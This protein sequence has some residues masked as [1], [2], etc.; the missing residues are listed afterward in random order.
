MKKFLSLFLSF[1]FIANSFLFGQ[2]A[3]SEPLNSENTEMVSNDISFNVAPSADSNYSEKSGFLHENDGKKHWFTAIGGVLFF[4]V[5]L[6]SYNRFVLGSGWA[7]V[8]PDEWNR[9]WEREMTYD[10]DWY[11]TNFVLH[12]YQ[13]SF[14]YQ[15][16]R[17]SNLNV[18]ESFA[19]TLFGSAFWEYLCET[20]APSINDMV[21]TTVGAF[22]MGAFPQCRRTF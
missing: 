14:Y 19:L 10:R 7:Q 2:N 5:G 21:Y 12:P 8:G 11:W 9:F 18:A 16:S 20:N 17:G 6:A 15:A 1:V 4:N 13:G 22:S 3:D